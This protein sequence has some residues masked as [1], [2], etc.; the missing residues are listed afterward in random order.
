MWSVSHV[1]CMES[2]TEQ[3]TSLPPTPSPDMSSR[4]FRPTFFLGKERYPGS[5]N[6]IFFGSLRRLVDGG[7]RPLSPTEIKEVGSV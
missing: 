7:R 3:H 2:R 6:L 4:L 5:F 1:E